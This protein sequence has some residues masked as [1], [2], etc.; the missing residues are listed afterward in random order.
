M[1]W[2]IDNAGNSAEVAGRFERLPRGYYSLSSERA[3]FG[4]TKYDLHGRT[5][6]ATAS[7]PTTERQPRREGFPV[8]LSFTLT[9]VLPSN[10]LSMLS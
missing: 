4:C 2:L 6:I 3:L 1:A 9:K 8:C 5:D 10:P 7:D